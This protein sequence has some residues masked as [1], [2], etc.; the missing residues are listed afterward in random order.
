MGLLPY[1]DRCSFLHAMYTFSVP[2]LC[3]L[4]AA[5]RCLVAVIDFS[6]LNLL[7]PGS[8]ANVSS[9]IN[10]TGPFYDVLLP[11]SNAN[12]Q[13]N[14]A[15]YGQTLIQASCENALQKISTSTT[16]YTVA[17]RGSGSRPRMALPNRWSGGKSWQ[18]EI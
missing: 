13:C 12:V 9:P 1:F 18:N 4:T 6:G 14:A 10:I 3:V 17:E 11:T 7:Q 16:Q 8:V 5:I 2:G 15:S